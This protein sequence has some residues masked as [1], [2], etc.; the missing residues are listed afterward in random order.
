MI[1][2]EVL[3]MR[4]EMGTLLHILSK[5]LKEVFGDDSNLDAHQLCNLASAN[6]AHTYVVKKQGQ[7]IGYATYLVY[8]EIF[9]AHLRIADCIGI[10]IEKKYRGPKILGRLLHFAETMLKETQDINKIYTSA[11]LDPRLERLYRMLG[12]N[13]VNV[14]LAKGI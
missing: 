5:H 9:R 3:D 13:R 2:Y 14:Q 8:R 12:Y 6:L 1:T 11:N 7:I 4:L 10:Y